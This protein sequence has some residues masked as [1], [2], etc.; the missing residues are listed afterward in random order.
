MMQFT[1]VGGY[2]RSDAAKNFLNSLTVPIDCMFESDPTNPHD[3]NAVKVIAGGYHIG[4]APKGMKSSMRVDVPGK[5]IPTGDFYSRFQ[6]AI[7]YSK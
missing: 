6:P 3:A 2:Y 1:L 5:V 7:E 4:F